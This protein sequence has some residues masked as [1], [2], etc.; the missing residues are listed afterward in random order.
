[1]NVEQCTVGVE[2]EG[3]RLHGIR[4]SGG[5]PDLHA[6]IKL[7]AKRVHHDASA[8]SYIHEPFQLLWIRAVC[9]DVQFHRNE[10]RRRVR[11]RPNDLHSHIG[12]HRFSRSYSSE[13][14]AHEAASDGG[15]KE[16]SSHGTGISSP[17]VD[18]SVNTYM[19]AA[20]SGF[21]G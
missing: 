14:I 13:Q 9:C 2:D 12:N 4:D 15:K 20:Q 8:V 5:Y 16:F 21:R 17:L 10:P 3:A 11:E 18:W 1:M 7:S 19:M 6:H